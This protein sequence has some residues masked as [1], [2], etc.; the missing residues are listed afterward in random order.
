MLARFARCVS[1]RR[2]VAPLAILAIALVAC[3]GS[4]AGS[5]TASTSGVA[6]TGQPPS[7]RS[8]EAD[9]REIE[10]YRLT[11][12]KVD[13]YFAATLASMKSA[14]PAARDTADSSSDD[15]SG[16]PSIDQMVAMI[17][18]IPGARGEFAKAGISPRESVVLGFA[19]AFASMADQVIKMN[20]NV[21]LDSL[22]R[23]SHI[24]PANIRFVQENRAKLEAKQREVQAL[25]EQ[26]ESRSPR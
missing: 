8:E 14:P 2:L 13:R 22:A 19:L 16:D 11:M 20:P 1:T 26:M 25:R 18:R 9:L 10:N 15:M 17:E 21:N 6:A 5:D 23:E 7:A 12:D 24:N 4:E 3:S